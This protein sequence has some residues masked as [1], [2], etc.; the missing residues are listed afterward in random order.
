MVDTVNHTGLSLSQ[1]D[2]VA[3]SSR[4]TYEN[5]KAKPCSEADGKWAGSRE[6]NL[7]SG[8]ARTFFLDIPFYRAHGHQKGEAKAQAFDNA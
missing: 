7:D 2:G 3:T 6:T 8:R 1:L 5:Q 4:E